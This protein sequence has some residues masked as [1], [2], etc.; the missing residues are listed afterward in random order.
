MVA[1]LT[2]CHIRESS[3]W[4]AGYTSLL[5]VGFPLPYFKFLFSSIFLAVLP[6]CFIAFPPPPIFSGKRA[7][8]LTV[9]IKHNK[10]NNNKKAICCLKGL[11]LGKEIYAFKIIVL[12]MDLKKV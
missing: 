11:A 6:T 1:L 5:L 10:N 7:K 3:G 9:K 12:A 8:I 4:E 2:L